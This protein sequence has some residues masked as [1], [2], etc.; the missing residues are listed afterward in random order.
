MFRRAGYSI[1][2]V[3]YYVKIREIE[4]RNIVTITEGIRYGLEP[5]DIQRYII[6]AQE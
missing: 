2:A 4:F 3:L 6:G 1:E 5:T